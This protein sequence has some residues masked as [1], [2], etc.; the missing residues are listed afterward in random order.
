MNTVRRRSRPR[1]AVRLRAVPPLD[2][3]CDDEVPPAAWST[4]VGGQLALDLSGRG[5]PVGTPSRSRH[6][7]G[8]PNRVDPTGPGGAD[9]PARPGEPGPLPPG[10]FAT[11]T[12]EARQAAH[13]FLT[14]CLEIFNGYRPVA[15]IRP[16]CGAAE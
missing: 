4:G 13:R 6:P 11:A 9:G 14:T 1:P 10:A 5:R 8:P 15:H 2:P 3:P 16:V 7:L 12:P